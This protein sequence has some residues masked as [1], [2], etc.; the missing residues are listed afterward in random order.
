M[1]T[2]DSA[3]PE[4]NAQATRY[5]VS[6]LPPG[7]INHHLFTLHVEWRGDD[8]W[9]VIR[10]GWCLGSNG[11][12]DYER[13]PS[14]REDEWL[15]WHRFDLDTAL[16]LAKRHAPNVTVNGRTAVEVWQRTHAAVSAAA[17]AEEAAQ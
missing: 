9:A 14:E 6:L 1:N 7:D 8:R 5:E 17:A 3:L 11:K 4:P 13:V 2:T 10:H 12:W 16:A 15:S